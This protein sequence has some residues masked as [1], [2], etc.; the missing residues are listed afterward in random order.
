MSFGLYLL[1]VCSRAPKPKESHTVSF[2]PAQPYVPPKGFA[3]INTATA[4]KS[5]ATQF[6]DNLGSEKQIW[7]ITAPSDISISDLKE[8][9]LEKALSGDT[10]LKIKDREY[11]FR[12]D[13]YNANGEAEVLI[14][15]QKGYEAGTSGKR[16]S[17]K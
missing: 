14:P 3:A 16:Y 8:F 6:F 11:G 1:T 10:V 9:A 17:P 4:T 7:H 5:S 13:E 2:R 15:K 12:V